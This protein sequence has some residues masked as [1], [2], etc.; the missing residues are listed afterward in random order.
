MHVFFNLNTFLLEHNNFPTSSSWSIKGFC[1]FLHKLD[2]TYCTYL[3]KN[4]KL[5]QPWYKYYATPIQV[6]PLPPSTILQH[7]LMMINR[8]RLLLVNGHFN[9]NNNNNN[10]S[11]YPLSEDMPALITS[12]TSNRLLA[13][14]V[15]R[16]WRKERER[17]G[18][19]KNT[20][21]LTRNRVYNRNTQTEWTRAQY[22]QEAIGFVK[23]HVSSGIWNPTLT[24]L[25]S[26][27]YW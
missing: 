21:W 24:R 22:T 19:S 8:P 5:L 11:F 7:R 1:F 23:L 2:S 12:S 20:T 9:N 13:M 6:P 26:V 14:V 27:V 16:R 17:G 25:G 4:L 15:L 10:N 18:G 3:K